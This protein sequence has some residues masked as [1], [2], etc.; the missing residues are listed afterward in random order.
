MPVEPPPAA[1]QQNKGT[2]RTLQQR[3]YD[4]L[5]NRVAEGE[6]V[7]T[8]QILGSDHITGPVLFSSH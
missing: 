3:D 8:F 2:D 6:R 4:P 7:D 1:R 5:V